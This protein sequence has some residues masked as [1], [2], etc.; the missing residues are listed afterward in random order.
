MAPNR[1][2]TSLQA[3][4]DKSKSN[5]TYQI[6]NRMLT[7]RTERERRRN[8][9]IANQY[10]GQPSGRQ[11][12]SVS[13]ANKSRGKNRQS[14]ASNGLGARTNPLS[15]RISKSSTPSRTATPR[16]ALQRAFDD[17]TQ[18]RSNP[19]NTTTSMNEAPRANGA[20]GSRIQG[21]GG[22][23]KV[24]AQNF[25]PSTTA[26]DIE[27]AMF[28]DRPREETG[29]ISCRLISSD[30]TVIAELVF[31]NE[32]Q[33]K[34]IIESFNNRIADGRVLQ[35]Y[36]EI[37]IAGAGK[38]Q[39]PSP[40]TAEEENTERALASPHH[41]AQPIL[42]DGTLGFTERGEPVAN[43]VAN[44]QPGAAVPTTSPAAS[45][46][47]HVETAAAI[48]QNTA[49]AGVQN[50][51]LFPPRNAPTGPRRNNAPDSERSGP[52]SFQDGRFGFP[53]PADTANNNSAA[54]GPVRYNY[55]N[56]GQQNRGYE[57]Y[58]PGG[59]YRGRGGR[60]GRGYGYGGYGYGHGQGY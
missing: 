3:F 38:N 56:S 51:D 32:E 36:M 39:I 44:I 6:V 55:S 45:T 24:I 43:I 1:N 4:V 5:H 54:E 33:A 7:T 15:S 16:P 21:R 12:Q 48:P 22:R 17:L 23:F 58:R 8:E 29:L 47:S 14:K 20:L 42:V 30:P 49:S 2:D 46:Q 28:E 27:V 26:E 31:A 35:V 18:Y 13:R 37:S 11:Q 57:S 19:R 10:L 50:N 41:V 34:S 60:S 53:D 59:S 25:H 9:E 52:E 40:R